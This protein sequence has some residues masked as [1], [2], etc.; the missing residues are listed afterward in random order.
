MHTIDALC[1]H[2]DGGNVHSHQHRTGS[3]V[4]MVMV[5]VMVT[6]M[7]VVTRMLLMMTMVI[8]GGN[9]AIVISKVTRMRL[10]TVRII[11]SIV[12]MMM[13]MIMMMIL[14]TLPLR[15][16]GVVAQAREHHQILP[17]DSVTFRKQSPKRL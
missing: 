16:R 4:M 15:E 13:M 6:R 2:D 1:G 8:V 7:G 11:I 10:M 3:P 17:V 9:I 5:E 14:L 12:M